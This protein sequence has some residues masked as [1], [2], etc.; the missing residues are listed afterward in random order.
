[1]SVFVHAQGIKTVHAGGGGGGGPKMAKFCPRSCWM[2]PRKN[3]FQFNLIHLC[4]LVTKIFIPVINKFTCIFKKIVVALVKR[5][6]ISAWLMWKSDFHITH[7]DIDFGTCLYI[8]VIWRVFRVFF[9]QNFVKNV[10][11]S[12]NLSNRTWITLTGIQFPYGPW[13]SEVWKF[14][15]PWGWRNSHAWQ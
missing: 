14:L 10:R 8:V 4:S 2:T 13:L 9:F 7:E 1:M 3:C 5:Y 15:Q 12:K 11:T 6:Q